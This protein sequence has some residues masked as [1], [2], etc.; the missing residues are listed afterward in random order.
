MGE[1]GMLLVIIIGVVE[2][3]SVK[4]DWSDV[5]ADYSVG[6]MCCMRQDGSEWTAVR[7]ERG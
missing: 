2:A 5:R 6:H 3:S 4:P 7:K 1:R